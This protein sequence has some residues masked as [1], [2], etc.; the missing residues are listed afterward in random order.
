VK[1]NK[2]DRRATHAC[3]LARL[4]EAMGVGVTCQDERSVRCNAVGWTDVMC[5]GVTPFCYGLSERNDG[6][7]NC[8]ITRP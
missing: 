3:V 6:A 5:C 4:A 1:L 8:D 2:G 7:L